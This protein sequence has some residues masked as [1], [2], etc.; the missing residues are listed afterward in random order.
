MSDDCDC[1]TSGLS[2]DQLIAKF[3]P[4]E[5]AT[6]KCLLEC[7]DAPPTSGRFFR[8]VLLMLRGH[9]ANPANYGEVFEHL[10]CFWWDPDNLAA[11]L[12]VE[13]A[14]GGKDDSPDAYP[15]IYVEFGGVTM[16]RLA[17]GNHSGL[18][19]DMGAN[20]LAKRS[21]LTLKVNHV[22]K[23]M[24]D[25]YDLADMSAVMF[26]ALAPPFAEKCGASLF[27]V[28]GYAAP[29]KEVPAPDRYYTVAMTI[30]ISYTHS[31][32]RSIE[33]HRIRQIAMILDQS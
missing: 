29:K 18:S 6:T 33:S 31:V 22:A 16:D 28:E 9:Y 24:T 12:A 13:P 3:T 4:R 27:E 21:T 8:I 26:T 1:R 5:V 10:K 30:K 19:N 7:M 11:T 2:D 23:E 25:A 20:Y 17:L 14:T 15:G 32:T